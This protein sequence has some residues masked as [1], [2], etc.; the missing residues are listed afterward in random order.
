MVLVTQQ[1]FATNLITDLQIYSKWPTESGLVGQGTAI[2]S[3][4][5]L[6]IP[7]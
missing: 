1:N 6:F 2:E 3:E 7:Y 5:S 4:G